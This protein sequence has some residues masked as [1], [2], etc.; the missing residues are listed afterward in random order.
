MRLNALG[1]ACQFRI[2]AP[3]FT[4]GEC[5]L[6]ERNIVADR[7]GITN[8]R[9]AVAQAARSNL[10]LLRRLVAAVLLVA[11]AACG[12]LPQATPPRYQ[13]PISNQGGR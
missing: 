6:R 8:E 10:L 3:V 4:A 12:T 5:V 7:V 11:V 9:E 13:Y 2:A 1:R